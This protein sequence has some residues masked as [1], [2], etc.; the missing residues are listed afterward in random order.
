MPVLRAKAIFDTLHIL[1]FFTVGSAQ[2]KNTLNTLYCIILN[3]WHNY[4]LYCL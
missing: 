3:N 2:L 4:I 1:C